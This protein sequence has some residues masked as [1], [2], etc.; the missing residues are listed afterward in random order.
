MERDA[1]GS[2]AVPEN[3]E[4]PDMQGLL[5][6][7]LIGALSKPETVAMLADLD[8][9]RKRLLRE[10]AEK[11]PSSTPPPPRPGDIPKAV[12]EVLAETAAPMHVS[13]IRRGVE[14]LLKR[15]VNPR[16]VKACLSEGTL[17]RKPRFK[18]TRHGCYRLS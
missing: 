3:A 6:M 11:P 8:K 14:R 18:R 10:C 16:S 7:E 12:V 5:L 13:D 9:L 4:A 17:L 1:R 2:G 15:P